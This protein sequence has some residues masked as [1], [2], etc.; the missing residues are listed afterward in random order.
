MNDKLFS[1]GEVAKLFHISISSLRHY[2]NIGL[3]KPEY[4]DKKTG[5]RYYSV[6]Q[7]EALNSIRYL[8]ELNMPLD[9]IAD[10]LS[11]RDVEVIE[12]KL[13]EQRQSVINKQKELKKIELK[14]NNRLKMLDDAKN[15]NFDEIFIIEKEPCDIVWLENKFIIKNYLDME[16]LIR[17]LE[18]NQEDANVFLGKVGL[19][20]SVENLNSGKF[21]SYDGIF[22]ILDKEDNYNGKRI[23]LEKTKCASIRFCGSHNSSSKYYQIL[24][25]YISNN[26]YT[27]SSFAREITMIDYG[28]TNDTSKF[29]TEISIP[30]K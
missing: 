9:E 29:V 10:F 12:E 17:K 20:I 19:A 13:K 3:L 27:I 2:E 28:I 11:N 5:Y 30:I 16:T 18:E 26:N 4:V 8:R 21:E 14:I 1:I 25:N 15:S 22:L 7:F 6:R 24:L 23:T